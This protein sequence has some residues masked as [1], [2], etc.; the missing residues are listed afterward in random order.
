MLLTAV[1]FSS[2]VFLKVQPAMMLTTAL[3]RP[4]AW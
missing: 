1:L 3:G 4:L 2:T